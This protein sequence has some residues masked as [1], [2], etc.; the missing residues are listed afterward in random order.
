M[1]GQ[2]GRRRRFWRAV[3]ERICCA[4]RCVLHLLKTGY[5]PR[6]IAAILRRSPGAVHASC[7]R[8]RRS[9]KT[10]AREQGIRAS[11]DL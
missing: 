1:N 7:S 2:E 5:K 3:A 11:E 6:E 8:I 4:D 9:M 10:V